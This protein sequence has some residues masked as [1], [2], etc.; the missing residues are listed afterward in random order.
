MCLCIS[1]PWKVEILTTFLSNL[2][3]VNW[4]TGQ[5]LQSNNV[6]RWRVARYRLKDF[7]LRQFLPSRRVPSWPPGSPLARSFI[8]CP[9]RLANGDTAQIRLLPSPSQPLHL[10]G[11]QTVVHDTH[12]TC[13]NAYVFIQYLVSST[14]IQELMRNSYFLCLFFWYCQ[15]EIVL[16]KIVQLWCQRLAQLPG[17]YLLKMRDVV[18]ELIFCLYGLVLFISPFPGDNWGLLG[19]GVLCAIPR[20][21]KYTLFPPLNSLVII[22]TML[23]ARL[24][25]FGSRRLW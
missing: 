16:N 8:N 5:F 18:R 23:R 15:K 25:G 9:P 11:S 6:L 21:N 10:S 19:R 1:P 14:F 22:M 7:F 20:R 17:G 3:S 24:S 2:C 4:C 12:I 13:S